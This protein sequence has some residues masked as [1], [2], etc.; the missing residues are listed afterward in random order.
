MNSEQCA[1]CGGTARLIRERDEIRI[2][3][4]SATVLAEGFRCDNCGEVY[5][6]PDQMDAAMR[7][8]SDAIR[9]Q[10]DLLAGSKI[11]AIRQ[12]FSLTQAQLEQLLNTGPKTVVRWER[13]TVFQNRTTDS[14][15]RCLDT[16]PGVFEYLASRS[17][18]TPVKV[19][20]SNQS[21]TIHVTDRVAS[22]TS[23]QEFRSAKQAKFSSE[24]LET[25]MPDIPE[26]AMK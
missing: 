9:S 4:R 10:E 12:K 2:G 5:Y 8:A 13:G 25:E 1:V 18:L 6:T 22:V 14:L 21:Q 24:S 7:S 20:E 17:G 16:V 3:S 11:R 26:E 23:I 19:A 15:L